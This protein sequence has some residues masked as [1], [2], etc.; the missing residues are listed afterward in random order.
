M[1]SKLVMV[2]AIVGLLAACAAR[3]TAPD[4]EVGAA[5]SAIGSA[6]DAGARDYSAEALRRARELLERAEAARSRGDY[7]DARRLAGEAEIEARYAAF[8]ARSVQSEEMVAELQASI[9]DLRAEIQA[10][11]GGER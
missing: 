8:H 6:E 1:L 3:P 2:L 5:R 4:E 10:G 9:R 11:S 7:P